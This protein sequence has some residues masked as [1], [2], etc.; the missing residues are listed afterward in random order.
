MVP[1]GQYAVIASSVLAAAAVPFGFF[2]PI[3]ICSGAII[4]LYKPVLSD[5]IQ[6]LGD[7]W[8]QANPTRSSA[9]TLTS[10][11]QDLSNKSS[12]ISYSR[13]SFVDLRNTPASISN[14]MYPILPRLDSTYM[15]L[16]R[17]DLSRSHPQSNRVPMVNLDTVP[18]NQGGNIENNDHVWEIH[19]A[20]MNKGKRKEQ[21]KH[22][23]NQTMP[24]SDVLQVQ[25]EF[26]NNTT[27]SSFNGIASEIRLDEAPLQRP[28]RPFIPDTDTS[29]KR[30]KVE[31]YVEFTSKGSKRSLEE[32]EDSQKE[33]K[34]QFVRTPIKVDEMTA[35]LSSSTRK[36]ARKAEISEDSFVICK[37]CKRSEDRGSMEPEVV[38]IS[39]QKKKNADVTNVMMEEAEIVSTMEEVHE[40]SLRLQTDERSETPERVTVRITAEPENVI[41]PSQRIVSAEDL[42]KD[43]EIDDKRHAGF[44][45]AFR[46]AVGIKIVEEP[47]VRFISGRDSS[48]ALQSVTDESLLSKTVSPFTATVS[49]FGGPFAA[50]T[51]ST[52]SESVASPAMPTFT[53]GTQP[54]QSDSGAALFPP[55]ASAVTVSTKGGFATLINETKSSAASESHGGQTA[56]TTTTFSFGQPITTSSSLSINLGQPSS[57]NT[58]TGLPTSNFAPNLSMAVSSAPAFGGLTPG[59][60]PPTSATATTSSFTQAPTNMTNVLSL[61]QTSTMSTFGTASQPAFGSTPTLGVQTPKTT[62]PSSFG[63]G[64]VFGSS[65]IGATPSAPTFGGMPAAQSGSLSQSS[66]SPPAFGTKFGQSTVTPTFGPPTT[67]PSFGQPSAAPVFGQLGAAPTFGQ[68]TGT[69]TFAMPAMSPPSYGSTPSTGFNFGLTNTPTGSNPF[70]PP[71][72]NLSEHSK[73]RLQ[74]RKK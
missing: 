38:L 49:S 26:V 73:R 7:V 50:S 25:H 66:A 3:V 20:A 74:R 16:S 24:V 51:Q 67:T 10:F 5:L 29:T 18:P 4:W 12:E 28:K 1:L 71:Q 56:V 63:T 43:R 68:P 9:E 30:S 6:S 52:T 55:S 32:A 42:K 35:S 22:E 61:Q 59:S 31:R 41:T 45:K 23:G 27:I 64:N 33:A 14:G 72:I 69:P 46:K 62:A 36:P 21:R 11:Q 44:K 34:K 60:L 53:N 40:Q 15:P 57:G 70:S 48:E 54:A 8:I 47:E 58:A 2:W 13:S 39:S 37:K 19:R 17:I 65:S